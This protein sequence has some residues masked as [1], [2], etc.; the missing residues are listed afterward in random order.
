[1]HNSSGK[2]RVPLPFPRVQCVPSQGKSL[3]GFTPLETVRVRPVSSRRRSLTG[4]TLVELMVVMA[5]IVTISSIMV[6]SQNSFNRTLI[7]SNT[8]YDIALT[9]R[10]AE[11]FGMSSRALEGVSASV[12]YGLYFNH[13]TPDS[14]IFFKDSSNNMENCYGAPPSGDINAPDAK[15]GNC[16]YDVNGEQVSSYKLGNGMTVKDFCILSSI[17]S[18]WSCTANGLT[19]LNIVFIRP[20]PNPWITAI[21]SGGSKSGTKACITVQAPGGD[22]RY[23]SVIKSGAI[24]ANATNC[25]LP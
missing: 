19:A 18:T 6:T 2:G 22:V 23:V 24:S 11:T 21:D 14:F 7:L 3:T 8:A 13:A 15:H 20:D 1:M 5:I 9:L 12:G 16:V 17:T 4:F 25:P 10:Y